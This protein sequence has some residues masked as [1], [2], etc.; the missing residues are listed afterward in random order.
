MVLFI[1]RTIFAL[2]PDSHEDKYVCLKN[3]SSDDMQDI[4]MSLLL[5]IA[6]TLL[7]GIMWWY[8]LTE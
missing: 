1:I 4:Y 8:I 2:L 7:Q 5:L 3:I 6:E